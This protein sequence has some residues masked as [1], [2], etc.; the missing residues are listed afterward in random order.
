MLTTLLKVFAKDPK[1][2]F[3][4]SKNNLKS[5]FFSKRKRFS[6]IS[7]E[8]NNCWR[9]LH[10]DVFTTSNAVLHVLSI[11]RF[12]ARNRVKTC[13]ALSGGLICYKSEPIDLLKN[14]LERLRPSISIATLR[15]VVVFHTILSGFL[16]HLFD[17][18]S[19]A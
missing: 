15:L 1:F 14:S 8:A 7:S 17:D 3:S 4:N 2:S 5:L 13:G 16:Y 11:F 18:F 9:I 19:L 6:Q 10:K 12:P